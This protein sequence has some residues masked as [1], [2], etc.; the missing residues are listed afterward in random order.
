MKGSREALGM[1]VTV[2]YSSVLVSLPPIHEHPIHSF[3]FP[4]SEQTAAHFSLPLFGGPLF[5]SQFTFLRVNS[6]PHIHDTCPLG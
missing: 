6:S 5:S 3:S 2:A 4:D 1:G